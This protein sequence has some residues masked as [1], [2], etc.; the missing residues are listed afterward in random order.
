MQGRNGGVQLGADTQG[1]GGAQPGAQ[2]H[3]NAQPR[4]ELQGQSGWLQNQLS[5]SYG[6]AGN[7]PPID[8]P[9]RL[10]V[11]LPHTVDMDQ[12]RVLFPTV[13]W[14]REVL[15]HYRLRDEFSQSEENRSTGAK[16]LHA[17][18]NNEDGH[19]GGTLPA[20]HGVGGERE[21]DAAT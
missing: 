19:V 12:M 16:W 4:V 7:A 10:A 15:I 2:K 13:D 17:D 6:V 8:E 14:A 21:I 11:Y 9:E 3:S 18:E 1:H 5:Q 20:G